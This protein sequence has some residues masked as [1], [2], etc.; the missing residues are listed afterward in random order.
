MNTEDFK[1][2]YYLLDDK[3]ILH[4]CSS[5]KS[6]CGLD[7]KKFAMASDGELKLYELCKECQLPNKK[8]TF[9]TKANFVEGELI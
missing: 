7:A 4:I 5:G 8:T 6:R 1:T 2:Y 9:V 3:N